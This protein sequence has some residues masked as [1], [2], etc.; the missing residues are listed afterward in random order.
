MPVSSLLR[1]R[2][3]GLTMIEVLVALSVVTIGLVVVLQVFLKSLSTLKYV[4]NRLKS[5]FIVEDAERRL[6]DVLNRK[7]A[8]RQYYNEETIGSDPAFTVKTTLKKIGQYGDL[9]NAEIDVTWRE[10]ARGITV[11]RSMYIEKTL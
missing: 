6:Q 8:A 7:A 5:V 10:G 11:R 9:Y 1:H 3:R 4:N 2:A